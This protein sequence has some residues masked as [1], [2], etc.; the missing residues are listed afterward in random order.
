MQYGI[1]HVLHDEQFFTWPP[2]P[3]LALAVFPYVRSVYYNLYKELV[4][5]YEM[6]LSRQLLGLPPV[7]PRA[8]DNQNRR[9]NAQAQGGILG[10]LQ[11]LIDALEQDDEDGQG[12]QI[13]NFQLELRAEERE[14]DAEEEGIMLEMIV[15][16]AEMEGEGGVEAAPNAGDGDLAGEAMDAQADA[17]APEAAEAEVPV[18][19]EAVIDPLAADEDDAAPAPNVPQ[20][21]ADNPP[22]HEA[23]PAPARR[24]G[25]G[26]LLSS[27]SNALVNALI[28]PGVSFAAGEALRLVLPKD[29]TAAPLRN[30]WMRAGT[31]VGGRPGLFQQQWGR[32]LVGGCLFVVLRDVLR[33]YTKTRKVAALSN[34][35]VKNVDR[36]RRK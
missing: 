2:S 21:P 28:L 16:E 18:P 1:Y 29:W 36:P 15:E 17:A 20:A 22:N 32:S 33:V 31:A 4:M 8:D 7:E 3:Q 13:D 27:V 19:A 26:A 34:R 30:P 6:K 25:L 12:P 11:T 9:R 24:M 35:R 14:G 10:I 5:P 23:P